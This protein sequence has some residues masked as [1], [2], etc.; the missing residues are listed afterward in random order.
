MK[1]RHLIEL[2]DDNGDPADVVTK[3]LAELQTSVDSRLKTIETK[4][5]DATKLAD[6]LDKIEAK[7]NRPANDNNSD[8]A[9]DNQK[10]E[11]KAFTQY[12]RRGE[13]ALGADEAKSLITSDDPRGGYFSPPQFVTSVIHQL[14]Q[15]SPVRAA[16]RVGQTAN[17]SVVLP[18]RTG[19]TNALW[20]GEV[21]TSGESDPDFAQLEIFVSGLRT[22]TDVSVNLLEDSAVDLDAELSDALAQ[23]FGKK[24]GTAFVNGTGVKQ[25]RGIMVHPSV[26]YVPGGDA[27]N[28]LAN[29]LIDLFYTLPLF[30]RGAGAW[31]M[32]STT[33]GAVRKLTTT[34]GYPLWVDSLAAGS[35]PTILGRPVI[36]AID[37]P[38]IAANAFPIVFGNFNSAYRIYD[39]V[40]LTLLRDPFTQATNGLV[41]FHARRRVGGDVVLPEAIL[42]LKI[43][44]S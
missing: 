27:N 33:V 23:D 32:N 31:M 44:T 5:A 3:A 41:R 12:I 9:N 16:A 40:G 28:L 39:R 10:I 17:G 38:D 18:V 11:Q 6:R 8:A 2:K 13:K 30:Y 14:V 15:F 7:L 19:V 4:S 24:E 42:K 22:Y 25:P 34:T 29:S 1:P 21:E 26:G 43:A 37:M 35:P 20:E 36:E